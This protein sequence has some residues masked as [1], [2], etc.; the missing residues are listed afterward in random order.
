MK[1]LEGRIDQAL[2]TYHLVRFPFRPTW[3]FGREKAD[4]EKK[5]EVGFL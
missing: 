5:G 4:V 3:G 1:R 2:K